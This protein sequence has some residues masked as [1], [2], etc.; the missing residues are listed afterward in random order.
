MSKRCIVAVAYGEKY[1]MMGDLMIESFLK[2]NKGW[3]AKRYYGK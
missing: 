1:E 2:Y 3:E